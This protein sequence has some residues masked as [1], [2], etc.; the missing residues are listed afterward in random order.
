VIDAAGR[1]WDQ[2][3]AVSRSLTA[4]PTLLV[5]TALMPWL[6]FVFASLCFLTLVNQSPHVAVAM[7]VLGVGLCL[8]MA[9]VNRARQDGR[10]YMFIL[11]AI[12]LLAGSMNG[13][14]IY[15]RYFREYYMYRDH[16][17][18]SNVWPSESAA[19]HRDASALV[20][21]E[22]TRVDVRLTSNYGMGLHIY[23]VAP[24]T[25][26][27]DA[28]MPDVQYWAAGI[29]CCSDENF[30]CGD[31]GRPDARAGVV[32]RNETVPLYAV[33]QGTN[34]NYYME[35]ARRA[36]QR[37]GIVSTAEQPI[38]LHWAWDIEEGHRRAWWM[39]IL[40]LVLSSCL[41]L[42]VCFVMASGSPAM[43]SHLKNARAED[44]KE[45]A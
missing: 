7:I 8:A 30:D 20:F 35:A 10:A 24:V 44:E 22:G 3:T 13:V 43:E 19:A 33:L 9:I 6:L 18:Y 4:D 1:G 39:G 12:A 15:S 28:A 17:Q 14:Y 41:Y 37:F 26:R 27:S 42:F 21:A 16:R 25:M 40:L 45:F 5:T 36:M 34:Y 31:A 29:D 38:F 23:C 11:C 32:I 2:Y